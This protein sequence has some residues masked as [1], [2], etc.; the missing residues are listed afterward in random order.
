MTGDEL[1]AAI[2]Q[3]GISRERAA[4]RLGIGVRS[5]YRY[6]AGERAVPRPVEKQMR[7]QQEIRRMVERGN[8]M[9]W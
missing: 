8:D 5:L 6:L 4:D 3:F 1:A 2:D 9:I 7:L